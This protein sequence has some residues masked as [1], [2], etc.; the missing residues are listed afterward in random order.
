MSTSFI[1]DVSVVEVYGNI[2]GLNFMLEEFKKKSRLNATLWLDE[3]VSVSFDNLS[4]ST[5]GWTRD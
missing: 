2:C 3:L 4:N 5:P 1:G